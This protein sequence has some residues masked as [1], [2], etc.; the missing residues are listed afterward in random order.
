[1]K[2]EVSEINYLDLTISLNEQL[3]VLTLIFKIYFKQTFIGIDI[4]SASLHPRVHKEAAIT[5][6]IHRMVYMSLDPASRIE[7][8]DIIKSIAA[9]N[10]YQLY[11]DLM[12]QRISAPSFL[13]TIPPP[14]SS[15]TT[16]RP[17]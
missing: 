2:I 5:S 1:M 12:I 3:N 7:E 14:L 13:W 6:A 8:T 10:Q 9:K 11:I 4:H 17:K 15:P 16:N